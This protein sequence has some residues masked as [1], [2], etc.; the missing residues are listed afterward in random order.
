V[1]NKFIPGWG[2]F[3]Y[4]GQPSEG[5]YKGIEAVQELIPEGA[6]FAVGERFSLA[7]ISIVTLA[8]RLEVA[9]KNDLGSYAVGEGKKVYETLTTNPKYAK[10]WAYFGR[11]KE[12]ESFKKTFDEVRILPFSRIGIN[13]F[14]KNFIFEHLTKHF[15]RQ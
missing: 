11:L 4:K 15:P 7:D 5:L 2:G 8:A 10:F 13:P 1:S 6:H 12:R 9:I 14:Y 3:I